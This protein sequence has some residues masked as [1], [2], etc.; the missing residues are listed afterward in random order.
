EQ[1]VECRLPQSRPSGNAGGIADDLDV[2]RQF[3]G[4]LATVAAADIEPVTIGELTDRG[5]HLAHAAVPLLWT[6][7]QQRRLSGVLVVALVFA[8][9]ML[10][11][12]ELHE[13]PAIAEESAT[14]PGA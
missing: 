11:K 12:L 9:T 4:N 2:R 14:D 5:D 7:A 13:Q 10:T 6:L 3:K 8:G 1:L